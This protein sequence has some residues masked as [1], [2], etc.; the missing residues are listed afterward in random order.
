M[1]SLSEQNNSNSVILLWE[2]RLQQRSSTASLLGLASPK[3]QNFQN[4]DFQK[5]SSGLSW[6]QTLLGINRRDAIRGCIACHRWLL[7]GAVLEHSSHDLVSAR[8]K[9][10]IHEVQNIIPQ[11][12]LDEAIALS[13]EELSKKCEEYSDNNQ[14][15]LSFSKELLHEL[16][17]IYRAATRLS[18]HA[19][20]EEKSQPSNEIR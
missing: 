2:Q 6:H 7:G 13:P 9:K 12:L 20:I 14:F 18:Q 16:L 8:W 1:R 17:M 10:A 3:P 15:N 5:R 19:T 11:A 4:N